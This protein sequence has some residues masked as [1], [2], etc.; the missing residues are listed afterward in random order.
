MKPQ[1]CFDWSWLLHPVVGWPWLEAR[2]PPSRS[3]SALLGRAGERKCNGRLGGW[4]EDGER[5]FPSY[6]HWQNRLDLGKLIYFIVNQNQSR[7]MRHK[8]KPSNSFP[9]PSLL[10]G[11]NIT[12]DFLCLPPERRRG[13]G[14]GGCGQLI[15]RCLCRSVLLMGRTPHPLHFL[16]R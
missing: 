7:I 14:N 12:P 5:S 9:H 3:V 2:C 1:S 8:P 4:D 13:T 15:P 6:C 10:P 16:R 11:P